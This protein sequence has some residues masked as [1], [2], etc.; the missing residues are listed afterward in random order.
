MQVSAVRLYVMRSAY[1][2]FV[3]A[4]VAGTATLSVGRCTHSHYPAGD[5]GRL[6][7]PCF[8]LTP[9]PQAQDGVDVEVDRGD[10]HRFGV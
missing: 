4:K 2:A 5:P 8:L 3:K 9:L 1:H 10:T 6:T 7:T